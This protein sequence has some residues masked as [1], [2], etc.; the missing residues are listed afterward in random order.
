VGWYWF[1]GLLWAFV[2]FVVLFWMADRRG[3][4]RVGWGIFGALFFLLAVIV[5]L[6]AGPS[7]DQSMAA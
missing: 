4:H 1:G 5:I 3:R 2:G 7:K 6:I